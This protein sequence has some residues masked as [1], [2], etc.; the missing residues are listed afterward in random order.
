MTDG[1]KAPPPR[2]AG[3]GGNRLFLATPCQLPA[4]R[5]RG[6][7][8]GLGVGTAGT[9]GTAG[10]GKGQT[11][12]TCSEGTH[13]GHQGQVH[14]VVP[15]R[16]DEH[17]AEGLLP[18]EGRVQLRGLGPR[19][20]VAV[21]G[22]AL[23]LPG[24]LC[25]PPVGEAARVPSPPWGQLTRFLGTFSSFIQALRFLRA[26][27]ISL[28]LILISDTSASKVDCTGETGTGF[29]LGDP[30]RLLHSRTP[31]PMRA[32]SP[33]ESFLCQECSRE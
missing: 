24:P 5:F 6:P 12:L 33:R 20:S 23:R 22:G 19:A 26:K 30:S 11:A 2:D 8:G 15:G 1:T 14:G 13:Q 27:S 28:S 18:D 4:H 10:S 9:A 32:S 31:C 16:D 3:P 21:S 25:H 7:P 17:Q 29:G